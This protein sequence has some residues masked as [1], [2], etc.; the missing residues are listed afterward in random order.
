MMNIT[1]LPADTYTVL[2]K[3]VITDLD[4]KLITTLYQPI[5]GYTAVSLYFTLLDNLDQSFMSEDFTH[6]HLMTSMQLKLEK[7]IESREKLEAVGLLKTYLKQEHVNNYA[8][9]V[10]APL[11]ASEFLNHPILSVVLYNNL[12]KSE[13]EKL[14]KYFRAPR[15][16][17]KDY[18]DV[19][20]HFSD[21]FQ[22]TT[23]T[24][25][26]FNEDVLDRHSNRLQIA[27]GIDLNLLI[28]SI[29]KNMVHEKCFSSETLELIENLAYI[30]KLDMDVLIA[31]V[32]EHLNEKGMLDKLNLRKAC[33]NYYQF[34]N[35]GSLPTIVYKTQPEYLRTPKGDTSKRAHLI[36][37]FETTSPYD[38]LASKCKSGE[39]SSRDLRL[40]EEL[41][42]DFKLNPGVVNVLLSY[43][44]H[45]NNQ[46]LNKNYVETIAGQ[47]QRLHIE[48]VEDAL[49][50]TKKEYKK[51]P[52]KKDEKQITKVVKNNR[53][54]K[55]PDWFDKEIDSTE[56][57]EQEEEEMSRLLKEMM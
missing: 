6:H 33:R 8:Y 38:F 56:I 50:L 21:V 3:S 20:K 13:Y 22:S 16:I 41:M 29:P 14:V 30:Y 24:F 17:L 15:I 35:S 9:L 36:Y 7:I 44:L 53:E 27:S 28:E 5:I 42:I 23:G 52:K 31:L 34:E 18:Q 48:T 51:Y 32:R 19:S 40:I 57:S 46:K 43:V 55:I 37:T 26:S 2:C 47:W 39:P 1:I 54:E 11:T 4:R 25:A 10:F 45:I 49:A 12:G